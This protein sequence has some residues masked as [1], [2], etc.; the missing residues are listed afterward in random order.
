MSKRIRTRLK[1][2]FHQFT[3]NAASSGIVLIIA[4]IVAL[5]CANSALADDYAR[6]W[7]TK[8]TFGIKDAIISKPILLWINDGLM[9]MFF[10]VVGLE[11][12]R[13]IMAGELSSWKKASLPII[14][15][16]G[17][18]VIPALIYVIF[19]ANTPSA[20]GWGVPMATDI[21]FSLGILALLGKRVPLTLKIFLTALA[22]ADDLGAVLVIAFFYSSKITF[23]NVVIGAIFLGLMITMNLAG[24]KRKWAYALPG[25]LGLWLAFL[26]SGVHATIAGVLA[27][28]AIPARM[29]INTDEFTADIQPLI[30]KLKSAPRL[31]GPL[32]SKQQQTVIVAIEKKSRQYEVPLQSLEHSMHPWVIFL[33]MPIF[34]LSN[35]GVTI[36]GDI[37]AILTLPVSL[38]I[39]TGLFIGK[40]LGI[41]LFTW[42]ACKFKLASLPP[43]T[44]WWHIIGL[45]ALAG[46][47][48]TMSLFVSGLA[49]KSNEFVQASKVSIIIA[50]LLSG[51]MGY[52]ILKKTL[53]KIT[54]RLK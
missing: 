11:I 14:A 44:N 28:F 5:V 24:V 16:I 9:A 35:A 2:L 38:G 15:A 17:G 41:F 29:T 7:A 51:S 46:I 23:S 33:I 10:F 3:S 13:E 32:L 54:G 45:G 26:L 39:I 48:F 40:P 53:P 42:L 52:L 6:I 1:G 21:A 34:A 50:S 37:Q 8:L 49:F 20:A 47:G 36:S 31:K 30:D 25:I 19:N 22:I 43:G 12:K 18:M 27:A 4:S